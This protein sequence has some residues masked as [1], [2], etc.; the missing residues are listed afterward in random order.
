MKSNRKFIEI[1]SITGEGTLVLA[2]NKPMVR[3]S[4][5]RRFGGYRV[6]GIKPKTRKH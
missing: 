1:E 6:V 4:R 5:S 3:M 2:A